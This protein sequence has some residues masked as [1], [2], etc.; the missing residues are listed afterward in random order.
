[1]ANFRRYQLAVAGEPTVIRS[2]SALSTPARWCSFRR[3]EKRY[4]LQNEVRLIDT[5]VIALT[6][7]QV[8]GRDGDRA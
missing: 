4:T 2:P 1:M 5:L 6:R 7:R 8:F 3:I